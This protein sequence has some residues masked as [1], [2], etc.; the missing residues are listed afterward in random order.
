[1]FNNNNVCVCVCYYYEMCRICCKCVIVERTCLLYEPIE[2]YTVTMC[3]RGIL[4]HIPTYLWLGAIIK[5]N[6]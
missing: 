4:G 1:M 3:S 6:W 2:R 5:I